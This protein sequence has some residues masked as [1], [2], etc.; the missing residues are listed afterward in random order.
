MQRVGEYI[1][2][3]ITK[4]DGNHFTFLP[5]GVDKES[6]LEALIYNIKDFYSLKSIELRANIALGNHNFQSL[7]WF[8]SFN[9]IYSEVYFNWLNY[10]IF[11]NENAINELLN[12]KYK[13]NNTTITAEN[14]LLESL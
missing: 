6:I 12:L 3:D 2:D 14:N 9:G 13:K 11:T 5:N 1:T 4:F 8:K 7:E 10:D